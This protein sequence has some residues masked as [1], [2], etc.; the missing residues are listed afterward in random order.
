MLPILDQAQTLLGQGYNI[1][2]RLYDPLEPWFDR[3]WN[4]GD[5]EIIE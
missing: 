4:P 1:L 5:F 2:L 3:R